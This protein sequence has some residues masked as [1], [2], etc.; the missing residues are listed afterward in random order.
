MSSF[1]YEYVQYRGVGSAPGLND[2]FSEIISAKLIETQFARSV[3]TF[4]VPETHIM[5]FI[6]RC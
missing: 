3:L 2:K 5:Y 1:T 4:Y 6:R